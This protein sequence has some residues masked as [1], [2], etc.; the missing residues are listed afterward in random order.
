MIKYFHKYHDLFL[1][2]EDSHF[3][4]VTR[5]SPEKCFNLYLESFVK[6]GFNLEDSDRSIHS[7]SSMNYM[8]K[9]IKA[10]PWVLETLKHGLVINLASEPKPFEERNN[11]GAIL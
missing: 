9:I 2:D 7:F 6:N 4:K 11:T 5:D 8:D 10:D 1:S 3:T